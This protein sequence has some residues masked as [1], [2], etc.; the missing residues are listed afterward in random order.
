MKLLQ[1]FKESWQPKA[2]DP[3]QVDPDL[4][5]LDG[6]TRSAES[7][8]YSI[9]SIEFWISRNGQVREWLK[10][11]THLCV[12]L[13]IPAL[14]VVPVIT[15]ILWHVSRW[16][17]MLTSITGHLIVLPIL[18]LVAAVVILVVVSIAK[19]LLK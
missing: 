4:P 18:A 2:I 14:V 6:I 7:I 19:A 15:F 10:H 17:T 3:P 13:A 9:L 1:K 12:W 16:A 5:H 11:N 8:R